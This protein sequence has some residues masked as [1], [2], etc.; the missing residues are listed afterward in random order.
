[1]ERTRLYQV[2]H[3]AD[4]IQLRTETESWERGLRDELLSGLALPASDSVAH[5]ALILRR[6]VLA[7]VAHAIGAAAVPD[8]APTD[9]ATAA[10]VT[11]ATETA[12]AAWLGEHLVRAR[13]L[14][15]YGP[16]G[17][18]LSSTNFTL[19]VRDRASALPPVTA[20]EVVVATHPLT[21]AAT[22]RLDLLVRAV[23]ADS[24][25]DAALGP[26]VRNHILADYIERLVHFGL[27]AEDTFP[28]L[29]HCFTM[30]LDDHVGTSAAAAAP[31]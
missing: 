18:V 15:L 7:L 26:A 29:S 2:T 1:V 13:Y 22:R 4:G 16:L 21:L 8:E 9:V 14:P 20:A 5:Q 10:A 25:R 17:T 11:P 27:G 19:C 28:F 23:R 12:V 31:A 24:T 30:G 3:T 6:V